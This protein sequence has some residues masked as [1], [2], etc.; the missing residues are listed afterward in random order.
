MRRRRTSEPSPPSR[1]IVPA[2]YRRARRRAAGRPAAS[3]TVAPTGHAEQLG[4]RA[5]LARRSPGARSRRPAGRARPSASS[6]NAPT[7]RGPGLR[8]RTRRL[9]GPTTPHASWRTAGHVGQ[10]PRARR[11]LH[12]AEP[13]H[14][15]SPPTTSRR[16]SG[17]T[18][19]EQLGPGSRTRPAGSTR[20]RGEPQRSPGRRA[21]AAA[22]ANTSRP[23]KVP[24]AAPAVRARPPASTTRGRSARPLATSSP[25]SGPTNH[26]GPSP[27]ATSSGHGT[28]RAA[29]A[30]D[31]PPPARRRAPRW[32]TGPLERRRAGADVERRHPWVRSMT[33]SVGEPRTITGVDHADELVGQAVVRQEEDGVG[34]PARRRRRSA[35]LVSRSATYRSRSAA[36][37]RNERPMRTAGSSPALINR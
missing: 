35:R 9:G 28:P 3:S 36:G 16:P 11:Q 1:R 32:S 24:G 14:P 37:S 26:R 29:D 22:G 12:V 15:A 19:L 31:R 17:P 30:R 6:T 20:V 21:A 4:R 33:A 18:A 8:C 27:R 10:V 23:S 7:A 34:R 5:P 25:L 13:V 2:R